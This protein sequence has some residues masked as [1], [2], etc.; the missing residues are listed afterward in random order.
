MIERAAVFGLP[1]LESEKCHTVEYEL[2]QVISEFAR[3]SSIAPIRRC[4]PMSDLPESAKSGALSASARD[5]RLREGKEEFLR[6]LFSQGDYLEESFR[7]ICIE[8]C[9][10]EEFGTLLYAVCLISSFRADPAFFPGGQERR[11]E[12]S[13]YLKVSTQGT[14]RKDA[15]YGRYD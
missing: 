14:S 1:R 4:I 15:S 9:S 5:T 13:Q 7:K 11:C 2:P 3:D 8:G 10:P 6:G 12:Q